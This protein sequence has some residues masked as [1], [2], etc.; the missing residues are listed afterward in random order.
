MFVMLLVGG[1]LTW[2]A[3]Y[4]LHLRSE[5]YRKEVEADLTDFFELPSEV[6]RIRGRT[7]SSRAFEDVV[8]WLPDRRD[9]VFHCDTAVWRE[10]RRSGREENELDLIRGVLNLGSDTWARED[11]QQVLESGLGHN[12]EDLNLTRVSLEAFEINFARGGLMLCCRETSGLIDMSDPKDGIARLHAYEL[13]GHRVSQGVQIHARF[14]PSSGIE[15]SELL[16]ALPRVPLSIVGVDAVMGGAVTQGYFAGT[17]Q[18]YSGDGEHEVWLKGELDEVD[19]A[20]LTRSLAF[21][22]LDGRFSVSVDAARVAHEVVTHFRGRGRIRGLRLDPLGVLIGQAGLGGEAAF[23]FDTIDL[24]LG[25][26]NRLRFSGNVS[27]MSLR[28]WLQAWGKGSAT[29]RVSI[30]VNNLD[31]VDDAIKSADIEISVLPPQSGAGLIDRQLLLTAA[32]RVLNFT[33]PANFP[34]GILPEQVEYTEFGMRLLVRD[35]RL[36]ILGTHGP[37]GE[38]ILTIKV[39]GMALGIVKEQS[40][41]IDLGPMLADLRGRAKAYDADHV[42]DWWKTQRGSGR[43]S[44]EE[45]P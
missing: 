44:G 10:L 26:I 23:E 45:R 9:R 36:R 42:R 29:G 30:Q 43:R 3:G 35:N 14:L 24:A 8:V 20:E 16:L 4:G 19:L 11:Y 6:G 27:G 38:T 32:E 37:N 31:V 15:V 22:P 13:N 17:L 21:G 34:K 2:T 33:W 41:Y 18:Y 7:F 39:G 12:F 28:E 40:G 25:R 5:A 1:S